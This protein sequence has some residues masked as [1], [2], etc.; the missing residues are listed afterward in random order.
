MKFP[1]K[2]KRAVLLLLL[3]EKTWPH[4]GLHLSDWLPVGLGAD[5]GVPAAFFEALNWVWWPRP[6]RS[7]ERRLIVS[8][9]GAQAFEVWGLRSHKGNLTE[10]T[11]SSAFWSHLKRLWMCSCLLWAFMMCCFAV[12][13]N[14]LCSVY[15]FYSI[16]IAHCC[17]HLVFIN[18]LGFTWTEQHS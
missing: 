6:V 3:G 12:L 5:W 18:K 7:A 17:F 2:L 16:V 4:R 13:V 15:E 14:C 8:P 9:Q 11:S 1:G 10:S